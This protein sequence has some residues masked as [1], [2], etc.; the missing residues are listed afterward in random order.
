VQ[1]YRSRGIG[2]KALESVL[3]AAQA[4]TSPKLTKVT[5]HVQVSN[6]TAKTFYERHGFKEVDVVRDYYKK[7]DPRDAW[8]LEKAL[9]GSPPS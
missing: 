3:A 8:V 1:P 4:H 7:I 5:L 6:S 9:D 2:T